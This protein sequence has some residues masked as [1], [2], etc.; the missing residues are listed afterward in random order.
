MPHK[1]HIAGDPLDHAIE[2]AF[3]LPFY[4]RV[5]QRYQEYL[6]DKV[7]KLERQ[8]QELEQAIEEV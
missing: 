4:L 2:E 8:V 7:R 6:E 1:R 5:A 3:D